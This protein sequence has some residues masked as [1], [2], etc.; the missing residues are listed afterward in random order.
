MLVA[1]ARRRMVITRLRLTYGQDTSDRE[2]R[3]LLPAAEPLK[4]CGNADYARAVRDLRVEGVRD[5]RISHRQ[6]RPQVPAIAAADQLA[7]RQR[8]ERVAHWTFHAAPT[9][10][11]LCAKLGYVITRHQTRWAWCTRLIMR[12]HQAS[13]HAG[14]V[15]CVSCS[16]QTRAWPG[17]DGE[18]A[19]CLGS[20]V[21]S[22]SRRPSTTP[23]WAGS[24]SSVVKCIRSLRISITLSRQPMK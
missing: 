13:A 18:P 15:S 20:T 12:G 19:H 23:Y 17:M 2:D 22:I 5:P 24:T 7:R 14:R 1:P 21:L 11:A 3:I 9:P 10:K 6:Q 4:G 8:I 16:L